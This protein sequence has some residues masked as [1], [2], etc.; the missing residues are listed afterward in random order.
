[1]VIVFVISFAG[2]FLTKVADFAFLGIFNKIFGS[3]FNTLKYAFLV[4][5][6][7]MF[8]NDWKGSGYIISKEKKENSI[9]YPHVASLAPM[10]LPYIIK[11]V[12]EF[13]GSEEET[14]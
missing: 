11:E 12:K 1:L 13:K 4:S 14:E 3:V 2:K 8:F 7:F 5:V 10:I 9:L 6:I